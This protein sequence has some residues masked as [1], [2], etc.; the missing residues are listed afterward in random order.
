MVREPMETAELQSYVEVV[1][2]GSVAAAARELGQPRATITRRLERLEQRLGV[3]LLHR[4]TRSQGLTDAGEQLY[5]HARSILGVVEVAHQAMVR[6]DGPPSGRVRASLPPATGVF[7]GFLADFMATFPQVQLE[8]E[9]SSRHVDL[10]NER[11]DVAL[12][13]SQA[14]LQPGLIARR[15]AT[16]RTGAFA[17]PA[18]LDLH[19]A[20]RAASELAHHACLGGFEEGVRPMTHWPVLGGGRVRVQS[21][22]NSNDLDSLADC[23]RM[24]LGIALLPDAFA[25]PLVSAG[26]LVQ[27]LH[28]AIGS[29]GAVSIVYPERQFLPAAVRAF[30]DHLLAWV[31]TTGLAD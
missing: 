26:A 17:A 12:R 23:A 7:K 31:A 11:F 16:V 29:E 9:W 1:H 28:D 6:A 19:G 8:V 2:A 5:Q 3:R 24:G 15:I 22:L 20:P 18:Y 14:P 13:A 10:V 21:V 25:R 27:V 4:T 30:I